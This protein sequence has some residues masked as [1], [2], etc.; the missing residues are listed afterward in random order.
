MA[1]NERAEAY[2]RGLFE[3]AGVDGS[4][5]AADAAIEKA[6]VALR[7]HA[8]LRD[9]L[10]DA[11]VPAQGKRAVIA[12]LF[13]ESSAPVAAVVGLM[14][15]N[16]DIELVDD[17][18]RIF[19]AVAENERGAVV[20]RVT[21]A[22]ELDDATRAGLVEDLRKFLGTPVVLRESVDPSIVGGIVINVAGRV[23][24]GSVAA[25]LDATRRAL[26]TTSTGGEA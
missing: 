8:E 25:R 13:A 19:A 9:T 12:E 3:L 16:G 20:A 10:A 7:S 1:S 14:A 18:A 26:S 24:D 4:V 5:D 6:V 15:D 2:A 21:T 22:V 11:S 17:V 23:I